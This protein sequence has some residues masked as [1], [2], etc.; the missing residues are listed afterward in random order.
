MQKPRKQFLCMQRPWELHVS[1]PRNSTYSTAGR[2][3]HYSV[4]TLGPGSLLVGGAQDAS[5]ETL[6]GYAFNVSYIVHSPSQVRP[7]GLVMC[8]MHVCMHACMQ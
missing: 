5:T 8:H 3:A 1:G 4:T 6:Q 2:S 7:L